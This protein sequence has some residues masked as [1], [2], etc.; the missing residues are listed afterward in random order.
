M[1]SQSF[2]DDRF[3]LAVD[4]SPAAM[5]MV[6]A[7]GTIEFANAETVRMFGYRVDELVGRSI[8]M[9][10]PPR[11]RAAHSGLRQG[12]FASPSERPMG[13]GRDLKGTRKDGTEFPVE[14][15]LTPIDAADG[16]IVLAT[17]VDI[18]ARRRAELDLAQR[19]NDLE[20][21]NERLTQ[22]AY[23]ASHDLQEPLRKIA[24][25]AGLLEEAVRKADAAGAARATSVISASAVRARKMVDN[26]LAFSRVS[27]TETHT[28]P[29][30][31]RAEVELALNDL[32][33][34]IEETGATIRV[35][36]DPIVVPADRAQLARLIQNI[37]SNAIKYRKPGAPPSITIRTTRIGRT[38]VRLAIADAGVGFDEKFASEIFQPFKR[39]HS[40]RDYPGSGIGLAICKAIADRYGWT[41][42]VR[43]RPEEGST[44][45]VT[46]P[47][48]V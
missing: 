5:I 25:Y 1:P 44:F 19:A 2:S 16:V 47:T 40:P 15:G 38:R 26:L 36:I 39:L 6:D 24:V 31:L 29:L 21:A 12:F 18:T 35:E 33:A 23:V 30:D 11:S 14:I 22:F 10:V 9:L 3:R 20:L 8:D 48:A 4:A 13:V 27:G 41:L 28:Q 43:S 34:A 17:V 37:V 46:L 45:E 7:N 32:S 42:S